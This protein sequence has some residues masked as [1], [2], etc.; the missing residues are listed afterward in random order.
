MRARGLRANIMVDCSH[1]NANKQ[2]ELQLQV[3]KDVGEQL[4]SGNQ[5]LVGVMLESF[6][7]PGNQPS[8]RPAGERA[9]GVSV[10]DPCLG[11]PQTRDALH[12]LRKNL[13]NILP[14]RLHTRQQA[15]A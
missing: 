9:Y 4:R 15:V 1:A 6:L 7:Y 10:T 14:T 11:W 5:S 2:H 3:L 12:E 8:T 13:Q